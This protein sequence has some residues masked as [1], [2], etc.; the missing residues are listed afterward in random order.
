MFDIIMEGRSRER[1]QS[2][3]NHEE[4]EEEAIAHHHEHQELSLRRR[5]RKAP[6]M[7]QETEGGCL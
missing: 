2:L 6:F 5:T 3:G 7:T 4:G 1:R